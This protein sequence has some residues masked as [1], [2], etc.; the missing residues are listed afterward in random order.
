MEYTSDNP[1]GTSTGLGPSDEGELQ[2]SHM[3]SSSPL[4]QE[5]SRQYTLRL[6]PGPPIE[7]RLRDLSLLFE[8]GCSTRADLDALAHAVLLVGHTLY[9]W[10]RGYHAF[11]HERRV[12]Y[13]GKA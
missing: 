2:P 5:S 11:K 6:L 4:S 10:Q 8:A 13:N 9:A 3:Q 7:Q 1:V 12:I